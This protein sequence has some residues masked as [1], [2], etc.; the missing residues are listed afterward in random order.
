MSEVIESAEDYFSEASP[1]DV[2][3]AYLF[4]S[5]ARG[6]A[7]RESD[8]D[9]GVVLDRE[10]LPDRSARSRRGIRLTSDLIA[11]LHENDVQVVILNDAPPELAARAVTE[12]G[13]LY[14][15]DEE[16]DR[17]FVRDV[18]LRHADLKPFLERMRRIKLKALSSS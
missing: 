1:E 13:R 14:C 3:S 11:A 15:R 5:H 9:V 16:E 2:V 4:G 17:V 18:L 10:Q 12:G 8:V 7:H 6:T